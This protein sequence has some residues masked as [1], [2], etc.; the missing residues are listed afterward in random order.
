MVIA[1]PTSI[2]Y[3][4]IGSYKPSIFFLAESPFSYGFSRSPRWAVCGRHL[5]AT[6]GDLTD[7]W[8]FPRCSARKMGQKPSRIWWYSGCITSYTAWYHRFVLLIRYMTWSTTE[9]LPGLYKFNIYGWWFGRFLFFHMLG[10]II[11]TDEHIF[12][13]GRST[14]NQKLYSWISYSFVLL[15]RYMIC[16]CGSNP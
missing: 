6:R 16:F 11:P 15:I 12:Q 5:D 13:R 9:F 7:R 2:V 14:T 4:P 10:I 3:K 1:P 8:N